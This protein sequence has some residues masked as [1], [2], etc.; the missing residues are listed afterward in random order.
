MY[1]SR[2]PCTWLVS[3]HCEKILLKKSQGIGGIGVIP[4]W[5]LDE[6]RMCVP[7]MAPTTL[8]KPVTSQNLQILST[9]RCHV[10]ALINLPNN[11]S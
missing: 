7:S 8:G 11:P 5:S 3:T 9:N 4:R 10:G 2:L 6:K 1:S